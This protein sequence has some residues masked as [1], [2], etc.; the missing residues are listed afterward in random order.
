LPGVV[1]DPACIQQLD[2]RMGLINWGSDGEYADQHG[3]LE[4]ALRDLCDAFYLNEL[5][6]GGVVFTSR[7]V[8]AEKQ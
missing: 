7:T 4:P 8:L 5:L 3:S 2:A 1:F 6:D